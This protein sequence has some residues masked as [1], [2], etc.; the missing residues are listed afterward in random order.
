MKKLFCYLTIVLCLTIPA[1]TMALGGLDS[2]AGK[3]G[4][5]ENNILNIIGNTVNLVLSLVGVIFAVMMIAG[6]KK[7]EIQG[8]KPRHLPKKAQP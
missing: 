5:A 4:F 2:S 6:G 1:A 8:E 7:G 3:A